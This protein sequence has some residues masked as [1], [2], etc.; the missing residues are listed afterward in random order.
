MKGP[1]EVGPA[2]RVR[3]W[4]AGEDLM[5]DPSKSTVKQ[6]LNLYASLAWLCFVLCLCVC[7]LCSM[8][9]KDIGSISTAQGTLHC[10]MVARALQ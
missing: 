2:N 10:S 1:G 9:Q 7:A 6:V 3:L 4:H 8:L 5:C